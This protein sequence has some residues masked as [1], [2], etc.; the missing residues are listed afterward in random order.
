PAAE[1]GA[2]P[3]R[4]AQILD[5]E[6]REGPAVTERERLLHAA[7]N[8]GRRLGHGSGPTDCSTRGAALGAPLPVTPSTDRD[9]ID[10]HADPTAQQ[11]GAEDEQELVRLV[12]GQ[13]VEVENLHDVAA[14]VPEEIGVERQREKAECLSLILRVG[15][16]EEHTS[17]LQ[18]R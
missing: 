8:D 5:V 12:L 15:R 10:R 4:E 6:H 11:Q 3:G 9:G 1:D 14:T 2:G 7:E 13:L 17:E 18:S 16:S